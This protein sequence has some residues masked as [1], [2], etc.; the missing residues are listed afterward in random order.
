MNWP[1]K[2]F[3][4]N[5]LLHDCDPWFVTYVPTA[6]LKI[7][8][9]HWPR[10]PPVGKKAEKSGIS[11]LQGQALPRSQVFDSVPSS[12]LKESIKWLTFLEGTISGS[13]WKVIAVSKPEM[14]PESTSWVK[15]IPVLCAAPAEDFPGRAGQQFSFRTRTL[16]IGTKYELTEFRG[17]FPLPDYSVHHIGPAHG[18]SRHRELPSLK[19]VLVFYLFIFV[20]CLFGTT[21]AA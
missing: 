16:K 8:R 18:I 9:F 2:S 4:S 19:E 15:G 6:A 5:K 1:L 13:L 12:S 20:F 7:K 10:A 21:P 11:T 17:S 14:R 3:F